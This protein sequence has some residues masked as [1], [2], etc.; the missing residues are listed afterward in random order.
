MRMLI[1]GGSASGKSEYAEALTCALAGAGK[2]YYLATMQHGG[3]EATARIA[4]HRELRKEKGFT[5]IEAQYPEQSV[6][7][8]VQ[9]STVLLEDLENLCANTV[10]S[11]R[12][13]HAS[14]ALLRAYLTELENCCQNLIA[15]T[16]DL[17]RDGVRYGMEINMYLGLL[18]DLRQDLARR[19]EGVIEVVCGLPVIWKGDVL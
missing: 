2:K 10:F 8:L 5:T 16:G 14:I 7:G 11:D 13:P 3:P 6:A 15:V 17:D 12:D 4:R 19:W 9:G 1:I 18:R